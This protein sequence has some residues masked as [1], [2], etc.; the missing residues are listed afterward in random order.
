MKVR[1][2]RRQLMNYITKSTRKITCYSTSLTILCKVMREYSL[3]FYTYQFININYK[4]SLPKFY[5]LYS[6]F[7]TK[8]VTLS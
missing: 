2:H 5:D 6:P 8:L 1:V 4:I 3:Y 7:D